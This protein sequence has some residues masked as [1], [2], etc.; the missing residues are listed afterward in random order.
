MPCLGNKR[1]R[2]EK[3]GTH[4]STSGGAR[5]SVG[6]TVGTAPAIPAIS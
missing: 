4:L 2:K 1:K 3:K 5:G 6:S